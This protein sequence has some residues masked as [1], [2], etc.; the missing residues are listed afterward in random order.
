MNLAAQLEELHL[1]R[2]SLLPG[3]LFEF[4]L[5]DEDALVWPRLLEAFAENYSSEAKEPESTC[6]FRI[7]LESGPICFEIEFLRGY[8]R[9]EGEVDPLLS[10]RGKDEVLDRTE[11]VRWTEVVREALGQVREEHT[12]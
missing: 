7:S 1:I 4:A 10:V 5:P 11:Q 9:A 12:E 3:E 8:P 6:R 2:C